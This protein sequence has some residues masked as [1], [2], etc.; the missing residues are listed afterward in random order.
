MTEYVVEV[1]EPA[2]TA[3]H[4]TVTGRLEVGRD[5][6][7]LV[8]ADP[9][10]SRRHVV[11]DA[12]E[13]SLTVTDLGSTNGTEVNGQRLAGRAVLHVGDVVTL[14]ESALTLVEVLPTGGAAALGADRSAGAAKPGAG[15]PPTQMLR[16]VAPDPEEP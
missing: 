8:L 11:L 9:G 5:V 4:V 16:A 13:W 15:A 12:G 3:R 7:G 1:R 6:P 14:G 10:I 2:H